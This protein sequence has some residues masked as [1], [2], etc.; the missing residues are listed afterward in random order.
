M[1]TAAIDTGPDLT[2]DQKSYKVF[3]VVKYV[4]NELYYRRRCYISREVEGITKELGKAGM[5]EE[6]LLINILQER[7]NKH[8]GAID[9]AITKIDSIRKDGWWRSALF[10]GIGLDSDKCKKLVDTHQHWAAYEIKNKYFDSSHIP[11]PERT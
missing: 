3:E 10:K 8:N 4:A 5:H 9:T 11:K 2:L 6:K 1:T 7:A